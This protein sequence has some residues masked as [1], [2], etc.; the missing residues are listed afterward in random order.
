[1]RKVVSEPLTGGAVRHR[2][3][4]ELRND[5]SEPIGALRVRA[6]YLDKA[7]AVLA[8][9]DKHVFRDGAPPMAPGETRV[10]GLFYY[11]TPGAPIA[12]FDVSVSA[13]Q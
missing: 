11:G 9:K 12:S 13:L 2:A 6:R 10:A 5:C 7:G 1:M 4:I 3:E 8:T